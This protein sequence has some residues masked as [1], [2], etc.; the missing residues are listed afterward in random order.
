M[1][2]LLMSLVF[3]SGFFLPVQV[4]VNSKLSGGLGSPVRSAIISFLVGMVALLLVYLTL[5]PRLLDMSQ[6]SRRPSWSGGLSVPG[7]AYL[8][9]L[10]G[11]F[12]VLVSIVALPR[13]GAVAVIA[14]ALVGQQ[15][16][17]VAIDTLGL[18]K[19]PRIPLSMPRLIGVAMV[20]LGVVLVQYKK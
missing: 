1:Q 7:W 2:L 16:A 19:A 17:A 14:I 11:A 6:M 8:G 9:G 5:E 13:L 20:A 10:C 12:Y 18:F 4:A 3:L 15:A